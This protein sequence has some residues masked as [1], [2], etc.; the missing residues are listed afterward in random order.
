MAE[1]RPVRFPRA[2]FFLML[3]MSILIGGAVLK[4]AAS[5]VVPLVIAVLVALALEPLVSFLNEKAHLPWSVALTLVIVAVFLVIAVVFLL[6]VSSLRTIFAIYPR[7][8]ARFLVIYQNIAA[9][10]RLPFDA[11]MNLLNNLWDTAGIR[12][13][14]QAEAVAF[15]NGMVSTLKNLALVLL[16]ICFL[17]VEVRSFREKIILAVNREQSVRVT[18][19]MQDIMKQ[20]AKYISVKTVVSLLTGVLVGLGSLAV[21]LDFPILW[22]FLAFILNYIPTFGSIVSCLL[23]IGFAILQFW[24]APAQ[25]IIVAAFML[26]VNQFLGVIL[27]PRIQG[28]NLGISPFLIIASLTVWGWLWGFAG[29]ILAIPMMVI[30]Q[31]VC[32]NVEFMRPIAIL[33]GSVKAAQEKAGTLG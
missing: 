17:L 9:V 16:F 2:M 27:E 19:I 23:T 13:F 22:G 7:Y 33:M 26:L 31:I 21:G 24:P 25:P 5:V 28:K 15:S 3:F 8:E 6:L 30:L 1:V 20:V 18:G 10:L 12:N 14:M 11:E 32:E 29:M 4:L